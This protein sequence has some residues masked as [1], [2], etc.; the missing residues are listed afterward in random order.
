VFGF[1]ES[2]FT[3]LAGPFGFDWALS[4]VTAR[5]SVDEPA[6]V[7]LLQGPSVVVQSDYLGFEVLE[8]YVI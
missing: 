8:A 3:I 1:H 4:V 2:I 7:R 6:V 5:L